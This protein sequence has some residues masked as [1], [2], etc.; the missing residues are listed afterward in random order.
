MNVFDNTINMLIPNIIT[1]L[2]LPNKTNNIDVVLDGGA[3]CGS[4]LY[5]CIFY[6]K[7]LESRNIIN[8][9]R[10]SGCSIGVIIGLLYFMDKLEL[11]IDFYNK[12][13]HCFIKHKNIK[14][15]KKI[16]KHL[17][18]SVD[19]N[20]YKFVSDKLFIT[21]YDITTC[22]Q[23]VVSKFKN[24]NH[25]YKCLL[26]TTHVPFVIDGSFS[27]DTK[28][29]DGLK[30][31]IFQPLND[32]EIIYMNL[33]TIEMIKKM[34][35][36][37][38]EIN[39]S[40]RVI[41]GILDIHSFFSNKSKSKICSYVSQWSYMDKIKLYFR[42]IITNLFIYILNYYSYYLNNISNPDNI[43]NNTSFWNKVLYSFYKNFII[44]YL[45]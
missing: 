2:E 39:N 23:H 38:N 33:F 25:L 31:F 7:Q 44:T 16:I 11:S 20:F 14:I 12:V 13:R 42:N 37:R 19:D 28:Y 35:Y 8:I 40:E 18:D 17:I 10:I 43:T 36:V 24:N 5:G 22:H 3:F 34:L 1:N 27:C 21:Y 15:S 26:R 45:I 4:Y 6:L 9:K 30:P 41:T 29:V 32:R